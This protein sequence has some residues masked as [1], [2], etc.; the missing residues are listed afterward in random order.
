MQVIKTQVIFDD[1]QTDIFFDGGGPDFDWFITFYTYPDDL[2]NTGLNSSIKTLNL[3][4]KNSSLFLM[5]ISLSW[6]VKSHKY[7][8]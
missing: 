5:L 4:L 2:E 8:L 1:I 7:T 6:M 3:P